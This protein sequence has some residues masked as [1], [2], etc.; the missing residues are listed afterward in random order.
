MKIKM[1]QELKNHGPIP[2]IYFKPNP[3]IGKRTNKNQD[4]L[5][6]DI[7][8]QTWD[9]I[10]EMLSLYMPMFYTSSDESLLKLLTLMNKILKNQNLITGPKYYVMANNLLSREALQVFEHK[11]R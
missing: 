11:Y 9:I 7:K 3:T 2:P 5:K 1:L 10:I 8:T 6:F 4:S